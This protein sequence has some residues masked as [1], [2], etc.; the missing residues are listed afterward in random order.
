MLLALASVALPVEYQGRQHYEY[1]PKFFHRDGIEGF[2]L[3]QERDR[4][5]AE[6]VA[7]R[8]ILLLAVPASRKSDPASVRAAVV[9]AAE[10]ACFPLLGVNREFTRM[11]VKMG[12]PP[13]HRF[14][15]CLPYAAFRA[16]VGE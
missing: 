8:G 11:C 1:I 13:M 10:D 12:R 4:L 15:A 14:S 5:K 2:V 9:K 3:Q 16:C 7:T 6:L